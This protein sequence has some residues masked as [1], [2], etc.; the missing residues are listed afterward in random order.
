MPVIAILIHLLSISSRLNFRF[1]I[2]SNRGHNSLAVFKISTAGT[3]ESLVGH[4]HT[5]GETPRHF[6]F[7]PSGTIELDRE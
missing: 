7:D 4:F 2:V 6:Q 5:R 1:L 3:L